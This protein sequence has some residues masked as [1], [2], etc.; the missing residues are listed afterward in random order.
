MVDQRPDGVSSGLSHSSS[1][2]YYGINDEGKEFTTYYSL[3]RAIDEKFKELRR[4]T[5][6]ILSEEHE[7]FIHLGIYLGE[8]GSMTGDTFMKF[9]EK[10]GNNLNPKTMEEI[11]KNNSPEYYLKC[12]EK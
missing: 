10:Y 11:R 4:E 3:D 12:L 2:K 6:K 9:V 1:V 8:Y 5:T 7:L